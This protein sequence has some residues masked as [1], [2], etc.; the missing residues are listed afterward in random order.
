M[1]ASGCCPAV[2]IA[3]R[4][5]VGVCPTSPPT[6]CC[7]SAR[8]CSC[9]PG[10]RQ[11][12]CSAARS[13][14]PRM[15]FALPAHSTANQ[16]RR[17]P[18]PP[19]PIPSSTRRAS[20]PHRPHCHCAHFRGKSRARAAAAD[21]EVLVASSGVG[22]CCHLLRSCMCP[23]AAAAAPGTLP[24]LPHCGKKQRQPLPP[25]PCCAPHAFAL[26]AMAVVVA[27]SRFTVRA[28]A[29]QVKLPPSLPPCRLSLVLVY[30]SCRPTSTCAFACASRFKTRPL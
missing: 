17:R 26:Q 6:A 19:P 7:T 5:A 25:A 16:Q 27:L 23:R 3:G 18:P 13:I 14:C 28:L 15:R 24:A 29:Y 9:S 2:V 30:Y 20:L 22:G 10:R 11:L 1:R 8:D 12:S 4:H 21:T